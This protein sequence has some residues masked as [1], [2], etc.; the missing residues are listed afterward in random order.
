MLPLQSDRP[1]LLGQ[2]RTARLLEAGWRTFTTINAPKYDL[3]LL[4]DTTNLQRLEAALAPSE[5]GKFFLVWRG[6]GAA[7][8]KEGLELPSDAGLG[9]GLTWQRMQSNSMAYL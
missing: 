3:N 9:A 2:R 4:F 7:N 6:A 1:R 5:R 8:A